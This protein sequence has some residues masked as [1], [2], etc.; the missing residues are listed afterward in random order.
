MDAEQIRTML[1]EEH[2]REDDDRKASED[3]NIDDGLRSED[4]PV[5][6]K[7]VEKDKVSL[8]SV[9]EDLKNAHF[10]V[11]NAGDQI[12][13]QTRI[14][15]TKYNDAVALIEALTSPAGI[16][17]EI[18]KLNAAIEASLASAKPNTLQSKNKRAKLAARIKELE[19]S[20]KGIGSGG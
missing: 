18:K 8:N 10:I 11:N 7:V 16:N 3:S 6:T 17:A 14:G 13:S 5:E 4:A 2:I 15:S 20:L 1:R 19:A 9:E 12:G